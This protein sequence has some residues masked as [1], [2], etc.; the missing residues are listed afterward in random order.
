MRISDWSSDVCSSDLRAIL[1]SATNAGWGGQVQ[2]RVFIDADKRIVL[3]ADFVDQTGTKL[4]GVFLRKE[5]PTGEQVT[6]AESGQFALSADRSQINLLLQNGIRLDDGPNGKPRAIKFDTI[7][8]NV[9]FSSD[10]PPFRPRGEREQELT[11]IAFYAAIHHPGSP[12]LT[13]PRLVSDLHARPVRA[14]TQ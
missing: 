7:L 10:A 13:P 8:G 1:Y 6:T 14:L 12:G 4:K 9:A 3:T 11:L 5:T 2:P